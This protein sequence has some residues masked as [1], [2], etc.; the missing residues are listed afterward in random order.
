[1]LKYETV[2]QGISGISKGRWREF[3]EVGDK[4]MFYRDWGFSTNPFNT[5]PLPASEAGEKLLVG[6]EQTIAQLKTRVR[7]GPKASTIEGLNGIGKTS[8]ANVAAFQL[9]RESINGP[10][11][12]LFL[13]CRNEF[14]LNA[15]TSPYEFRTKVLQEVIQTLIE[16]KNDLPV[17]PGMT[18]PYSNTVLDRYL[19]STESNAY[20]A[21]ILGA[22]IGFSRTSAPSIGFEQSGFD[23][24][25]LDWLRIVFPAV[26]DGGVICIIDNLEVLETSRDAAQMLE[27]LRDVLFSVPGIRWI[28]CGAR[29]IVHGVASSPRLLGYLHRP[30]EVRDL[31]RQYAF[32]LFEKRLEAYR[33]RDDATVPVSKNDFLALFKLYRG[34]LRSVLFD[35]DQYCQYVFENFDDIEED[36]THID[37]PD[38]LQGEANRTYSAVSKVASDKDLQVLAYSCARDNSFRFDDFKR[39]GFKERE[40]F[41]ECVD[42][43]VHWG[44]VWCVE[45]DFDHNRRLHR[46]SPKGW[47]L[48]N[49]GNLDHFLGSFHNM[50][51]ATP[52]DAEWF[53]DGQKWSGST[54]TDTDEEDI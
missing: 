32:N 1:M 47:L 43:L 8:I 40:P 25:A 54:S 20:Q 34:N 38:W 28:M 45:D 11:D 48:E 31:Q 7:N 41:M 16:R 37:F 19:N 51:P 2:T 46:I 3:Q 30:I 17:R 22:T 50:V 42:R 5:N 52:S 39:F 33:V 44:V 21:G 36:V 15:E 18:D 6:R 14:Q 24:A 12:S 26:E 13:S 53:K 35:L 29:G 49:S 10:G 4:Q 9:E 23:K 27:E